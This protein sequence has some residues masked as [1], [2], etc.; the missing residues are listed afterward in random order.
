MEDWWKYVSRKRISIFDIEFQVDILDQGQRDNYGV[1]V[2]QSPGTPV[3]TSFPP[4]SQSSAHVRSVATETQQTDPRVQQ[5]EVEVRG[6]GR[7]YKSHITTIA[8][9]KSEHTYNIQ[10][11][12]IDR[13][14]LNCYIR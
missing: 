12:V 6:Q 2:I 13:K 3:E 9:I 10:S 11:I 5:Q 8:A 4:P 14:P 7:S 1:L